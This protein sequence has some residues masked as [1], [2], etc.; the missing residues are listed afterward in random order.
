MAL[1]TDVEQKKH[2]VKRNR[3]D[4]EDY[5]N[6]KEIVSTIEPAEKA[7]AK[8]AWTGPRLMS[9]VYTSLHRG[10]PQLADVDPSYRPNKTVMGELMG[11]QAWRDLREHTVGDKFTAGLAVTKMAEK[12]AEMLART[13]DA[14]D[15]ADEEQKKRDEY[16]QACQEAGVDP[17]GPEIDSMAGLRDLRAE[18]DH[19]AQVAADEL[20]KVAPAIGRAARV[21]AA[22][23]VEQ[24][25]D[26]AAAAAGWDLSK[27]EQRA[28]D[29][30]Q[31]LA[32]AERLGT[33]KMRKIAA[34]LGRLRNALWAADTKR[35]DAGPDELADI[36]LSDDL[37]RL[38]SGEMIAL[39]VDELWDDF[40]DRYTRK[41]LLTYEMRSV[42]KEATGGII[43]VED[44]SGSMAG[45]P[46]IWARSVG[47]AL[48]DVAVKQGRSFK[49][50][51]FGGSDQVF[52]FE[53]GV[54]GDT[55]KT[56]L[57]QR[58]AYA[59]FECHGG[60][61]FD[62]PLR[63]A[64]AHLQ[65]EFDQK[66]LTT[67]DIV[68]ATDGDAGP[69]SEFWDGDDTGWAGWEATK[70]ALGFRCWGISVAMGITGTLAVI[71]DQVTEVHKLTDASGAR[72]VF[73]NVT[74]KEPAWA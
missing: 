41:Q 49:G 2:A 29:P 42:A 69:A 70:K 55:T 6:A 22:E 11:D 53:F 61:E 3:W 1:G 74:S 15:A 37:N 50:I 36:T 23:A 9:D 57:E 14:Q 35:W 56:T 31:R 44:N 27:G 62:G 13:K 20:D 58:L 64:V 34:M 10:N 71:C 17:N 47:L 48:L 26:T 32:L 67:G 43:Y 4:V 60:T 73:E 54:D 12:L 38:T 52:E 5:S 30:T 63:A 7:L 28:M 68:F 19:A 39:A 33:E 66:G 65:A 8:A 18:A 25:E 46:E 51:V 21:V 16:L 24:A 59:E 72:E 45:I 40:V